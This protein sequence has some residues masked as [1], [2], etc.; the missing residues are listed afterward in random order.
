[1]APASAD[2][3]GRLKKAAVV[4]A[5]AYGSYQLGKLSTGYSKWAWGQE[6]NY[7]FNDWNTW[8]KADGFLCRNHS[9][10]DWINEQLHCEEY[11]SWTWTPSS[12]WFGGNGGEKIL[13][14]IVGECECPDGMHFDDEE[15][16]CADV[17]V[18]ITL[19]PIWVFILV[20]IFFP[21][22]CL[23]LGMLIIKWRKRHGY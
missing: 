14:I 7:A 12:D 2:S 19:W 1:M 10:C 17:S 4:G 21:L 11:D 8:R 22:S 23:A 13:D 5:A 9:D 6:H 15:M 16:E 18:F 3:A 20:L